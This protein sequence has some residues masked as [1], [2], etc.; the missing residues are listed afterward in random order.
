[1]RLHEASKEERDTCR[2]KL[3][4]E[5]AAHKEE[6][7]TIKAKKAQELEEVSLRVRQTVAKKDAII[8]GLKQQLRE[9][10]AV[11]GDL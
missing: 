1:M 2:N 7:A 8:Q 9:A 10:E 11:L 3:A 5:R 4:S 6:I